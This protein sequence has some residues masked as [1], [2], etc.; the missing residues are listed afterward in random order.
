MLLFQKASLE[1][2]SVDGE[3]DEFQQVS[4]VR[5]V[6]HVESTKSDVLCQL[7]WLN[8]TRQKLKILAAAYIILISF[9]IS[10]GKKS[11]RL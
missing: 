11:W 4:S 5:C 10:L 1:E 3:S 8:D 7:V 9:F 6:L 2:C